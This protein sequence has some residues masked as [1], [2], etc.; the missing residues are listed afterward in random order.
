MALDVLFPENPFED[1]D[2]F[3]AWYLDTIERNMPVPMS[4]V[5]TS[6]NPASYS[7][8]LPSLSKDQYQLAYTKIRE[9][10]KL[11]SDVYLMYDA[12][13]DTI[14]SYWD[15]KKQVYRI[16]INTNFY[17]TL[18]Y[19]KIMKAGITHELGHVFNGDCIHADPCH[20]FCGN[21]CADVRINASLGDEV[22]DMLS[23]V[24]NY[25]LSKMQYVPSRFYPKYKLPVN[26][27]GWAYEIAH[28]AYHMIE[29]DDDCTEKDPP[30]GGQQKGGGDDDM[31]NPAPEGE[32]DMINPAPEGEGE[33]EGDENEGGD[34]GE[35]TD[36]E[37]PPKRGQR[38]KPQKGGKD[39]EETGEDVPPNDPDVEKAKNTPIGHAGGS[40]E[41]EVPDKTGEGVGGG[42]EEAELTEK[43]KELEEKIGKKEIVKSAKKSI[44]GIDH[45]LES[46]NVKDSEKNKLERKKKNFEDLI[47]QI[48]ES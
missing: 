33:G 41:E 18:A 10:V 46:K 44:E 39:A 32:D 20:S 4:K 31:V 17:L 38:G 25:R 21:I 15:S 13:C 16:A 7:Q 28:N 6:T 42:G 45:L 36:G 14:Y 47:K 5:H 3:F 11:P 8:K 37:A 48:E 22:C 2:T 26:E 9:L 34:G 1:F 24:L 30:Q 35:P 40:A 23:S 29:P 27:A 19:P 43:E 12:S